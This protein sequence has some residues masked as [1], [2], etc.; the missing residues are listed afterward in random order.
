[1]YVQCSLIA[2]LH[3]LHVFEMPMGPKKKLESY[4]KFDFKLHDVINYMTT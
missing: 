4:K 3:N 2:K 1:M